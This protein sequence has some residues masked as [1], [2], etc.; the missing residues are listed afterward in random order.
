LAKPSDGPAPRVDLEKNDL[1]PRQLGQTLTKA[2]SLAQQDSLE[3][4]YTEDQLL[5]KNQ[6]TTLGIWRN[7]LILKV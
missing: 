7:R 6:T 4:P 3:G 2:Q 5:Q 1:R